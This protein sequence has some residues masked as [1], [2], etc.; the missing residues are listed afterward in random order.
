MKKIILFVL[1]VVIL[2]EMPL[3]AFAHNKDVHNQQL[4]LV[5]FGQKNSPR[6]S[7]I[8]AQKALLALESASYLALDQF[9]GNGTEQLD[10]LKAYKVKDLPE[11]ISDIDF[12]GNFKHRTYTHRGWNYKYPD[13]KA[14]WVVRKQIL[15]ATT[16]KVFNFQW[17]ASEWIGIGYTEKCESLAALVYYVHV[18]GDHE[19]RTGYKI[20]ELM[21][22]FARPH[23]NAKNPDIFFELKYHLS[24]LFKDQKGT[25]KYTSL[26]QE[27]DRIAGEARSLEGTTGGINTQ[28]KFEE[29]HGLIEELIER[30]EDYVP[31]LLAKEDYFKN[32]FPLAED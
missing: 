24:I 20:E 29:M 25:R 28:E 23:A 30:L 27:I 2:L 14:N 26:M 8:K 5:L 22:P 7:T 10:I 13:D 17:F 6:L 15:L 32:V 19:A 11:D 18:L 31:R 9:N 16:E 12:A 4:E 1:T 21:I 3:L